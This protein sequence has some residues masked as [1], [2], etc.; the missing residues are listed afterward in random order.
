MII[1]EIRD[2]YLFQD[3]CQK[4]FTAE[5]EDFQSID[6]SGGDK[7]NDGYVPSLKRLFAIYC[8]EKDRTPKDEYK[9]KISSDLKKAVTLRNKYKYEIREWIFVTPAPLFEELH[10]FITNKAK[11]VGLTGISWSESKI[12][13]ILARHSHL[14]T[15]YPELLIPD[16]KTDIQEGFESL[17]SK[18]DSIANRIT[19]EPSTSHQT[20]FKQKIKY[21][22]VTSYLSRRVIQ[23]KDADS[24]RLAFIKE[25]LSVDLF[26]MVKKQKRIVL[27][28]NAGGGKTT[29]LKQLA[30]YYSK[31]DSVFY[32]FLI[33]LNKYVN[34]TIA[35]LLP[36]YWNQIPHNELLIIL[37]GLDEIESKNKNDA[38]RHIEFFSEQHPDVHIVI[39]CRTNFYRVGTEYSSGKLEGFIPYILLGLG[40]KE[41]EEYVNNRLGK[42]GKEFD[43]IISKNKIYSLLQIPFYLINLVDLFETNNTLPKSKSEIFDQL[44]ASRIKHDVRKY[45]TTIASL[46]EKQKIILRTLERLALAMETLGRNYITE[47]E[48]DE[49]IADESLRELVKHCTTWK[50][51]EGPT[52]TWQFEHN[53]F[54]E[55]LAARTLARQELQVIKDFISFKPDHKKIIPS[56]INTLSFLV[57][58]LEKDNAKLND[59]FS[60]IKEIEP[61][62]AIKF[63]PDKVSAATRLNILK[64][65]FNDFK[66]KQVTIDRTKF[67]FAELARFGQSE[68]TIDFLLT[69]AEEAEAIKNQAILL[70]AIELLG[71]SDIPKYQRQRLE[72]L[73]MRLAINS[74][75]EEYLQ[76]RTLMTLANLGFNTQDIANQILPALQVSNKDDVRQGLYYLLY[77]SDYLDEYI[78]VFL[79]GVKTPGN[80]EVERSLVSGIEKATSEQSVKKIIA[81]FMNNP[82]YLKKRHFFSEKAIT[83]VT[84]NALA[85][86]KN[87]EIFALVTGLF[88][89]L[90]I[91]RLEKEAKILIRF[92]DQTDTRLLAFQNIFEQRHNITFP[93]PILAILADS[94]CIR[95][96]AQQYKGK[97]ISDNEVWQFQAY[98]G[99]KNND[100]SLPFNKLINEVSGNKFV[101]QQSRDTNAEQE[102]RRQNDINL[103][104]NKNA[105]LEEIRK[106]FNTEKKESL[107]EDDLINI[108]TEQWENPRFSDL[109]LHTLYDIANAA[110]SRNATLEGTI[111][112]IKSWDWNLFTVSKLH[113]YFEN[114]QGI[115]ISQAQKDWIADWCYS[116]LHNVDFK[117]ELIKESNSTRASYLAIY[118]WYFL[119]K[120]NLRYPEDVLLDLLSFDW[121]ENHGVHGFQYIEERLSNVKIQ[122][123]VLHNLNEG[124]E[125]DNVLSNHFDYCKRH[126]VTSGYPVRLA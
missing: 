98:L 95:F 56:W 59:I 87:R 37:D 21:E 53:N 12:L 23:A 28:A 78:D 67:E 100:L 90:V 44:L 31:E 25:E 83:A 119:R 89:A 124:I 107:S 102:Q 121:V 123:R 14:K 2:P 63:E 50:R 6:D 122:A 93:P 7:G 15:L 64:G 17:N 24:I 79:Q 109:A 91:A 115:V 55:Y 75:L 22:E 11:A 60:W 30:F 66:E 103:L 73:L 40:E 112:L 108:E 43:R 82:E 52:S 48:F 85:Y 8:P 97:N 104:F 29:Q 45:R 88:I 116:N 71:Y 5:Y 27:L 101:F 72:E 19:V 20:K 76:G 69:E 68:E 49:I 51:V 1:R 46:D 9:R 77:N 26:N 70:S 92:F 35:E 62:L 118:L 110:Q 36:L 42:H 33:S 105:F 120:L 114:N 3:L 38:I 10:R 16:L 111:S 61:E 4:V 18:M 58:I 96:F 106:V 86:S 99:H 13:E 84:E 126:K 39:S 117:T 47:D 94:D 34:Q 80:H 57:S 125:I 74:E 54:Q 113:E 32:P 65:I 41:I 81:Y